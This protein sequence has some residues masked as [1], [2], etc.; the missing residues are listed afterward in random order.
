[1]DGAGTGSGADSGSVEAKSLAPRRR[2]RR[3]RRDGRGGGR[4]RPS[5]RPGVAPADVEMGEG[6]D[7]VDVAARRLGIRRLHPEQSAGIDASL[8]GRDVLMVMPTGFGKSR[9]LPGPVDAAAEAGG[10][11]VAAARAAQGPARE[12]AS[13]TAFR[14]F[15]STAR[16]AARRAREALERIAAGGS[17]L[18]MTTPETLGRSEMREALARVR[19][20]ARG[21]RRGALHLG[22]GLRLPAGL[23]ASRRAPAH[24]RRTAASSR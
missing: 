6:G 7:P 24:A 5:Q 18:V 3:G 8:A 16:C 4:P 14:A 10:A 20:L 2:R 9:L 12:A 23:S 15:A 11:G 21:D 19:R 13:A 22:V 17:L 1:M